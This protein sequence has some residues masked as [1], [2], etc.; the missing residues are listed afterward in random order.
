MD[1][2]RARTRFGGNR[3]FYI[4]TVAMATLAYA[5]AKTHGNAQWTL[6]MNAC[7]CVEIIVQ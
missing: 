3:S 7:Y 1:C 6:I 5:F 2:K 4:M